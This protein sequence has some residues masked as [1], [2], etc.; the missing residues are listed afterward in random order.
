MKYYSCILL[1]INFLACSQSDTK[2]SVAVDKEVVIPNVYVQKN[3]SNVVVHSDTFFVSGKQY[4]GFLFQLY[5]NQK[6]TFS[7]ESLYHG[8]LHG[9]QKKWY[10]NKKL[11]E[12]RAYTFNK[13]NGKQIAFWDNGNKKFE[14][15]AVK[16]TYEGEMKEWSENGNLFHLAHYLNGQEE[17][18]QKM[19]YDNGKIRANYVVIKG[20]RYGLLGTKNC[21]NVSDSIFTVR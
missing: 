13:K 10:P 5:P 18:V 6:D 9:V 21:K 14:F 8:V 19:W 4:S 1:C 3:E 17:G 2:D 7:L 15:T 16:D 11:L 12:E 20:K